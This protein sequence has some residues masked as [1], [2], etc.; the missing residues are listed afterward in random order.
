MYEHHP[1]HFWLMLGVAVV[2]VVPAARPGQVLA[3]PLTCERIRNVVVTEPL[4][5]VDL[6]GR[7]RRSRR[8]SVLRS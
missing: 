6:R 8:I 4:G 7:Q 2:I 1:S 5:A 3:G